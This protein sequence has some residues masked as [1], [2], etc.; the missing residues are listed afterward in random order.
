[1]TDR[2]AILNVADSPYNRLSERLGVLGIAFNV[3]P[4][5]A[6]S[7]V[8]EGKILRGDMAGRFTR[9]LFLRDKKKRYFLVSVDEDRTL[10]LKLLAQ[11]IDARGH[12]SFA[13]ADS[14]GALLGVKPGALTPLALINDE[15]NEVTPV[16]DA[17]LMKHSQLNFHPLINTRSIGL[18]PQE[19][20]S[21]I[22]SCGKSA[23]IADFDTA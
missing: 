20:L 2:P 7:T 14:V 10:D 21:F 6:H 5:P 15:T 4:Y 16:I 1:M 23:I 8:E 17:S 9:N 11:K 19:L 18:S 3:V 22:S 12:L 13:S